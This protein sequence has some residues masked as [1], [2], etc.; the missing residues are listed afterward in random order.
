MNRWLKISL[1]SLLAIGIVVLMFVANNVQ[2]NKVLQDPEI[3]ISVVEDGENQFLTE[4]EL[5]IRL[6]HNNLI[7]P[8]QQYQ[9]LD[10]SKIEASILKM[11]EVHSAEV[12]T[13]IGD[14][15]R[16]ELN[17][18][19]PIARIFNNRGE[20]FYLDSDGGKML[21]SNLHTARVIVVTGNIPDQLKS[22]NV[23][24]INSS[25]KLREKYAL[26]E[27][28]NVT[29]YISKDPFFKAMLAQIQLEENGDFKMVPQVGGHIINFGS[30]KN[31]EE[32][33]AKFEKL[34]IFYQQGIPY[35]GW[36][37]Y[38]EV[39]VKFKGQIVC[40]KKPRW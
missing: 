11:N 6:Q 21:P 27:I 18:R 3:I 23:D 9:H 17:L 31:T 5:K 22:P 40:K 32:V 33:K 26:E 19:N 39:S 7:Y 1:V 35:E 36:R 4:K 29:N 28:Y 14:Q 16:I 38:S 8:N 10:L 2:Q 30:G 34:K 15:W 12:F 25:P 37:K 13:E 24:R 20:T